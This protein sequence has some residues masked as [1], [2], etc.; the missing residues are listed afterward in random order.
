MDSEKFDGPPND[1]FAERICR[2]EREAWKGKLGKR[3]KTVGGRKYAKKDKEGSQ[4]KKKSRKG[5]GLF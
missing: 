2:A 1:T 4:K 3:K 5:K